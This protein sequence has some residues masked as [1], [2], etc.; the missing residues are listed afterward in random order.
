MSPQPGSGSQ[1]TVDVATKGRIAQARRGVGGGWVHCVSQAQSASQV[2]ADVL[3]VQ[4]GS[5]TGSVAHIPSGRH[6][7][8]PAATI[9]S[10]HQLT[11]QVDGLE[12][13]RVQMLVLEGSCWQT[14]AS[15]SSHSS[16]A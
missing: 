1:G 6:I 5:T 12:Q 3:H 8:L 14:L 11:G 10:Q 2:S 15:F 4:F 9:E 13:G 7:P 16:A